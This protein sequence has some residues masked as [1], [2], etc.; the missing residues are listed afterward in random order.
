MA[1]CSRTRRPSSASSQRTTSS[2]GCSY[3]SSS[4]PVSSG[5][6]LAAQRFHLDAQA[7]HLLVLLEKHGEQEGLHG[8]RVAGIGGRGQVLAGRG[9]QLVE[10]LLVR[11]AQRAAEAGEGLFF[12]DEGLGDGWHGAS[13]SSTPLIDSA[14]LFGDRQQCFEQRLAVGGRLTR[15]ARADDQRTRG[16]QAQ[17]FQYGQMQQALA[18]VERPS[19]RSSCP[20]TGT[21]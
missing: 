5:I 11:P 20:C 7:Q 15:R 12:L 13:H 4:Q 2:C 18:L 10:S 9:E 8:Q 21:R 6:D 16:A 19:T 1:W 17:Q 3:K 14:Q